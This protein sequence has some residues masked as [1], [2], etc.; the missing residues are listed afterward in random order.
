MKFVRTGRFIEQDHD[1]L[2]QYLA[3]GYIDYEDGETCHC[4]LGF[5]HT[6]NWQGEGVFYPTFAFV[7]DH[8]EGNYH[9]EADTVD[10]YDL[11]DYLTITDD[12]YEYERSVI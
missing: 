9:Y 7:E 12:D 4:K 5:N 10:I 8:Y 6:E 2:V 11:A 1:S 3:D